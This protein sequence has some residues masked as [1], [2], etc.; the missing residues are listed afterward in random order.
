MLGDTVWAISFMT[1]NGKKRLD[2]VLKVNIIDLF[3]KYARDNYKQLYIPA[4]K[5]IGNFSNGN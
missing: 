1:E 2:Y 5:T 4:L 3:F